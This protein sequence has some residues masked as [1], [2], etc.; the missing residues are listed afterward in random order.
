MP[1]ASPEAIVHTV[2]R[3]LHPGAIIDLH[4]GGGL[5]DT[6]ARTAEALPT[7]LR[8]LQEHGYR[9]L[10]LSELLLERPAGPSNAT[11]MSRFWDW[12]E[13]AWNTYYGVEELGDDAILSVGSAIHYGPDVVLQDGTMIAPGAEVGE[14]HLDRT[15]VAHL[16]Q[17]YAHH[18]LGFALRR[19]LRYALQLLAHEVVEH[20]RY[21]KL[22]ASR[23][24]TLFW[25]EAIRL[26]FEVCSRDI[27]WHQTFLGWYQQMLLTRDHPQGWRRLQGKRW[28]SRTIWLSRSRLLRRYSTT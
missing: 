19:E 3:Q 15:R 1:I 10:G 25:K 4:D 28:E 27:G 17:A 12:Y 6:P 22:P 14:L 20:P 13:S 9:S 26:G 18:R 5:R 11:L 8:L 16:H 2:A 24:T 21:Q 7:L 23:S